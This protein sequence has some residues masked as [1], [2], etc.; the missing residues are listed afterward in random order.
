MSISINNAPA[1]PLP[2]GRRRT[3]QS[4]KAAAFATVMLVGLG[5]GLGVGAG[6]GSGPAAAAPAAT[7]ATNEVR[8]A[9]TA[10]EAAR[11]LARTKRVFVV[12]D[13]ITVG[14]RPLIRNSLRGQVA[15]VSVDAAISRF[16]P[17]GIRLLGTR[18]AQRA[19]VWVVALGTN[20]SPDARRMR[21]FVGEVLK[22]ARGRKVVWVNIVRPGGYDRV[23]RELANLDRRYRNLT[24]V[25]WQ[26]AI[27]RNRGWLSGDG[28]HP[29]TAGYR[30]HGRMI[31]AAA[32]QL[33]RQP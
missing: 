31:A 4:R 32:R 18:P 10:I 24:V 16:T 22:R 5:V 17:T 26:A 6:I 21:S 9:T 30:A 1:C 23:N 28:V 20:D 25:D 29:T 19:A 13:S 3:G 7:L 2:N 15:R 12:G 8:S 33:A 11:R 14:S 27:R